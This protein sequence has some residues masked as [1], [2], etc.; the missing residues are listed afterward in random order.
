MRLITSSISCQ[1]WTCTISHWNKLSLSSLKYQWL[2]SGCCLS[3]F[4]GHANHGSMLL[5]FIRY[6]IAEQSRQGKRHE[7]YS[8]LKKKEKCSNYNVFSNALQQKL[9]VTNGMK[10]WVQLFSWRTLYTQGK[11]SIV[12]VR[13]DTKC[14]YIVSKN[15]SN[16]ITERV[17][18]ECHNSPFAHLSKRI[19][20]DRATASFRKEKQTNKQKQRVE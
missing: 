10:K 9:Q 18:S 5:Q 15:N 2:L 19:T 12:D 7:S 16:T 14:R 20:E 13:R 11:L 8:E 17:F 1:W 4:G 6:L 3:V